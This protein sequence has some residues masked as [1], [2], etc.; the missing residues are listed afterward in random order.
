MS[1]GILGRMLN[2]GSVY[3]YTAA[4]SKAEIIMRAVPRPEEIVA[5]LDAMRP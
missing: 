2:F 1:Q 3:I 5:T 4:T